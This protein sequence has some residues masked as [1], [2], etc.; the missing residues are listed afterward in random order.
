M[1]GVRG[2][3]GI[4]RRKAKC[5]EEEEKET[6]K[7]KNSLHTNGQADEPIKVSTRGPRGPK[8]DCNIGAPS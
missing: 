2:E 3:G 1:S 6:E 5:L 8:K 7:E 4:W